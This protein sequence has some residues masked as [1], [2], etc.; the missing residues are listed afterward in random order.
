MKVIDIRL[1]IRLTLCFAAAMCVSVWCA[2]GQ[3]KHQGV[4]SIMIDA[5]HGGK[6]PG[7]VWDSHR[8]KD[9]NL[10]V[11]LM[12]GE[13]IE[14]NL[15]DVKVHYTRKTDVFVPLHERSEKANKAGVDLFLSIHVN[16]VDKGKTAP[17]GALTL[18][19]GQDKA[20]ANLDIAMRENDVIMYEDDYT[21]TYEGYVPGSAESFIIFS[22]MQYVN[23]EQSMSFANIIQRHYKTATPMPDRGARQ[24][25]L[26]VLWKT[27]MPGVL[28][29]LGFLS[30]A[31]D[32]KTLCNK[33]GQKKL[34]TAL[35]NSF[36]EY[37]G[38]VE[39]K[40]TALLIDAGGDSGEQTVQTQEPKAAKKGNVVYR[41][42]VCSSEKKLS[43]SGSVLGK[44]KSMGVT[45]RKVGKLYKYYVGECYNYSQAR[46]LQTKVRKTT[47]DAFVV[48][49]D[50]D[51]QITVGDA[52]KITG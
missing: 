9:I 25:N 31:E 8:E 24:Q 28:T 36:S 18:V 29:E 5:G 50:G 11:A 6:D 1:F 52:R 34:A 12:L 45:E 20:D 35:F 49:F 15:P 30:N 19:M 2:A 38:K 39:G 17:S 43:T 26:L 32:R 21:T 46:D 22:L 51:E 10:S 4:R 33:A 27:S 41:V 14:K 44:Y 13:M 40:S 48:A 3:Q 16:A 23:I 42:Q 7:T 47:K 37:K